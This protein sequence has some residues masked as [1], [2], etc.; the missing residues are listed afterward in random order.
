M[1]VWCL[2][3]LA[4]A[5]ANDPELT[6]KDGISWV[7]AQVISWGLPY[8]IGRVYFSDLTSMRELATA[9]FIGGIVYIPLCLIE[10]RLSPQL[11]LWLY[12]Y[13]QNG[14]EQTMRFGGYR[15]M[16]FMQ[17]GLAVGLYMTAASLAGLWLW[18]TKAM[19]HF[20]GMP[21]W[22]ILAVMVATLVLCKSVGAII[23]FAAAAGCLLLTRWLR[24]GIILTLLLLVPFAYVTLRT[25]GG[26]NGEGLPQLLKPLGDDKIQS[27]MF[28]F[29]NE[30]S[31][32]DRAM[33]RPWL[34]WGGYSR[35]FVLDGKGRIK[36]T[37]DS[38]WIIALGTNGFVGL[39]ALLLISLPVI[40]L[41]NRLPAQSW[42]HPAF[43]G[44][45]IFCV[46]LALY[47]MDN[48]LNNMVDPIFILGLGGLTSLAQARQFATSPDLLRPL[49]PANPL[50]LAITPS[51]VGRFIGS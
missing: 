1:I 29:G 35:P 19:R 10:I 23:F 11:H 8:L 42:S 30:Q 32:T 40:V 41:V 27:L 4:T 6:T 38:L 20:S 13:H 14:F 31:I 5:M 39:F 2:V 36:Y 51:A 18:R 46:L 37:P 9:V 22:A 24:S 16:V 15:P 49:A 33:Q 17:H 26:W 44:V 48:L 34:G 43:S 25:A 7:M 50:P 45:I 12:G 47:A 3:P 28:R 21:L